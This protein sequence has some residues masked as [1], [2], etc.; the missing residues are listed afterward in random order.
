MEITQ[1]FL[2]AGAL[3]LFSVILIISAVSLNRSKQRSGKDIA[4]DKR[5]LLLTTEPDEPPPSPPMAEGGSDP[6][7]I[8]HVSR[9]STGGGLILELMG[10]KARRAT[11][12]TPGQA[13]ALKRILGEIKKWVGE[14]GPEPALPAA[15]LPSALTEA[16]AAEQAPGSEKGREVLAGSFADSL[17][18][19]V[20]MTDILP[21][22][23]RVPKLRKAPPPPPKTVAEQINAIVQSLLA[24]SP[25]AGRSVRLS[26]DPSGG[27]HIMDGVE[28]YNAI[29]D[30]ENPDVKALLKRAV[31][32]WNE[33]N[34]P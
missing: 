23:R 3:L 6:L 24:Q 8:L 17:P 22:R 20:E 18:R 7:E 29:D 5:E 27:L 19:R 10:Q 12:M 34:R 13:E 25:L 9:D 26:E 11:D 30:V 4:R 15:P 28:K 14:T 32:T 2:I 21:F 31:K 33:K 16:Q 1:I